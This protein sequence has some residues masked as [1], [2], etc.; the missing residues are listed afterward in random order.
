MIELKEDPNTTSA[1]VE[2]ECHSGEYEEYIAKSD[3]FCDK[4]PREVECYFK[5]EER[6]EHKEQM[7]AIQRYQNRMRG[8]FKK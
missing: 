2:A 5:K 7:K 1:R 8:K 6:K 4:D 3:D